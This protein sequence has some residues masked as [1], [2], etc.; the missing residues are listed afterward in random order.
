MLDDTYYGNNEFNYVGTEFILFC[1]RF[2]RLIEIFVRRLITY[3]ILCLLRSYLDRHRTKVFCFNL[4]QGPGFE[5][6]SLAIITGQ[7][8]T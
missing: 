3:L 1:L 8:I 5:Y 4:C 7:R 2:W 6:H